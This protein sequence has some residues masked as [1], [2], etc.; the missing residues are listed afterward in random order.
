MSTAPLAAEMRRLINKLADLDSRLLSLATTIFSNR[1][2]PGRLS[3]RAC[4]GTDPGVGPLR[5]ATL[6]ARPVACG[7]SS[8]RRC[9]RCARARGRLSGSG[10]ARLQPGRPSCHAG[11]RGFE[12]RRSRNGSNRH[13]SA[14]CCRSAQGVGGADLEPWATHLG[15]KCLAQFRWVM[16]RNSYG[17]LTESS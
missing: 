11:G 14:G 4:R 13:C 10:R 16:G 15:H 17:L 8:G 12:S 9:S 5:F 2:G 7:K 3:P 6:D 1:L